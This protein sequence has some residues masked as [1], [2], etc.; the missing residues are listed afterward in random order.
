MPIHVVAQGECMSRIA[1]RYGHRDERRIYDHPNNAELKEKRPDPNILHPGD[2]VF[3]PDR[4]RKQKPCATAK[5]HEFT[6]R[7]QQRTIRIAVGNLGD[8]RI[9]DADYVLEIEGARYS[10]K[11]DADGIL[12]QAISIDAETGTLSIAGHE[13]AL[14]IGHLNPPDETEDDGISGIQARLRNLGHYLGPVDGVASPELETAIRAFQRD[15]PPLACDGIPGADTRAAL[16][17][18][19]G[20]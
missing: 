19:H 16:V 3:V 9:A 2:N 6:V 15:N 14:R 20:C 1:A 13:W 18:E 10:G 7:T 12:E 4:E 5:R 17:D 11:T 8:G